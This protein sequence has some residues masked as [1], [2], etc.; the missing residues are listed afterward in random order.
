MG[1]PVGRDV[2][3]RVG[4]TVSPETVGVV[5]V[6]I[7]VGLRVGL[8]VGDKVGYVVGYCVGDGVGDGV[9]DGVVTGAL[10]GACEVGSLPVHSQ[11][12]TWWTVSA[13]PS[14]RHAGCQ[15]GP[16]E[17]L[18]WHHWI[19]KFGRSS[20]QHAVLASAGPLGGS[21]GAVGPALLQLQ[22][23]KSEGWAWSTCWRQAGC[24]L[25]TLRQLASH[26]A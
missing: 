14:R 11:S 13:S 8:M 25:A 1:L 2:G 5:V 24:Q 6:G 4:T 23:H 10:V 3:D 21:V 22:L 12:H 19:G 7:G 18:S 16:F 20:R 15:L 17:Q 26:H 9:E